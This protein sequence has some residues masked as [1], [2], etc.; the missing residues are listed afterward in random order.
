MG[1]RD[2]LEQA[3][4]LACVLPWIGGRTLQSG[5]RTWTIRD[6]LPPEHGWA[7]FR[8]HGREAAFEAMAE[9]SLADLP[10]P[11]RS[12]GFLVGDRFVPDAARIDP[13]P[14]RLAEQTE[15]VHLY[16]AD[17]DR[18]ARIAAGR[19]SDRGPLFYLSQLYPLGPEPE[20]TAAFED[21]LATVTQIVGVTPALDAAFRL[22]SYRRAEEERRRLEAE[23][24]RQ[25]REA[26]RQKEARRQ[27]LVRQIGDAAGRRALA[28]YD[29]AAAARAALAVGGAEYLDHRPVRRG[30]MA[31]RFRLRG[32]RFG[33]TCDA[34]TLQIIDSGICLVD[35]TTDEKGDTY[36]TLESLP[37]VICEADDLHRLVQYR[38]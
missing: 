37:G 11:E 7:K 8:T 34:E 20:V 16:P 10:P 3:A 31:V 33:C 38:R 36:F 14:E 23:R 35:H 15:T 32:R 28:A 5:V 29:F 30:E 27:E 1:W 22:E 12:S 2:L 19:F 13:A 26:A 4:G 9:L 17:L 25:E 6:A 21:K 24:R 18:F